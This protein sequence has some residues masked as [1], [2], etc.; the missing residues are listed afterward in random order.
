MRLE[1]EKPISVS[2][3]VVQLEQSH[4][5]NGVSFHL[6]SSPAFP[7]GSMPSMVTDLQ[8][9]LVFVELGECSTN[10]GTR[11]LFLLFVLAS[12]VHSPC[13]VRMDSKVLL[14]SIKG[15]STFAN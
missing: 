9:V 2:L 3:D 7:T 15:S 14:S 12:K 1:L 4:I 11:M 13:L 8:F 5:T 10:P 6:A